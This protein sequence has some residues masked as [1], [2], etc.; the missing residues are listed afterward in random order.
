MIINNLEANTKL[1][2]LAKSAETLQFGLSPE[3]FLLVNKGK[4]VEVCDFKLFYG[5]KFYRRSGFEFATN[6][7]LNKQGEFICSFGKDKF[8]ANCGEEGFEYS[9]SKKK[10]RPEF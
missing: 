2:K 6:G 7:A 8:I 3:G 10:F 9:S 5:G 1:E 4:V